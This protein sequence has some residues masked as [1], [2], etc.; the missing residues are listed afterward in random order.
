MNG[1]LTSTYTNLMNKLTTMDGNSTR[2]M[3][4]S[5][6]DKNTC[7]YIVNAGLTPTAGTLQ[8]A[9]NYFSGNSSPILYPCQ[10][11]FIIY[12]T[13][14]LPNVDVA[15]NKADAAALWTE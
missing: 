9:I 12:V 15:G 11:N 10:K 1:T 8:E 5:A 14:G 4:C 6:G 2:Y 13:D 7:S 3:S